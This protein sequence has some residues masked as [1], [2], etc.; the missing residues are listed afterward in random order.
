MSIFYI[1][2]IIATLAVVFASVMQAS[3][4][5]GVGL[6]LVPLLALIDI[7]YVPGP[8]IL[9]SAVLSFM[10]MIKEK[11]HLDVTNIQWVLLGIAFGSLIGVL[12]LSRVPLEL[13][14]VLFGA[15]IV[16]AV[17]LSFL[18]LRLNFSLPTLLGMG[19]VSGVMGSTAAMGAPVLLLLYQH[20]N[21]KALRATLGLIYFIS[22]IMMVSFLRFTDQFGLE[23]IKLGAMLIPGFIIGFLIAQP[24][25]RLLDKGYTRPIAL[26]LALGSAF[27]LI[28]KS[29]AR[30]VV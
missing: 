10:M 26:L 20:H 29:I 2:L 6:L 25:A 1:N 27:Y 3:T 9:A 16:L 11:D 17:G 4:G 7:N 19:T 30:Y 14:G 8:V 15:L 28:I 13:L 24:L 12:T 21:G 22:S 5:L 18:N 23:Q